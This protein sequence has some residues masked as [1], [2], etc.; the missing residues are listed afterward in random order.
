M[1]IGLAILET[2]IVL[3]DGTMSSN[4]MTLPGARASS[5]ASCFKLYQSVSA[6]DGFITVSAGPPTGAM[7]PSGTQQSLADSLNSS[8]S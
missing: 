4:L 3:E 1:S 2:S 8:S 7:L 5:I 6:T